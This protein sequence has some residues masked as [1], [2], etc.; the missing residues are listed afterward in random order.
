[1]TKF[2][3]EKRRCFVKAKKIQVSIYYF[4]FEKL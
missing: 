4:I 3:D 1:M 2:W